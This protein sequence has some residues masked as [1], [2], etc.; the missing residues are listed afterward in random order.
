MSSIDAALA[1]IERL[2]PDDYINIAKI[3]KKFEYNHSALLK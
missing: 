1:F 3:A 2:S